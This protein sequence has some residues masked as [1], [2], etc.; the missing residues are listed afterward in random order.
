MNIANCRLM[1]L[2]SRPQLPPL[3]VKSVII[4]ISN[5]YAFHPIDQV[6]SSSIS[7]AHRCVLYAY[8][9]AHVA[10]L[11]CTLRTMAMTACKP[12]AV[13]TLSTL[14][15]RLASDVRFVTDR[16]TSQLV[17]MSHEYLPAPH[18]PTPRSYMPTP[19]STTRDRAQL[20]A[21]T[22]RSEAG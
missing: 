6:P 9:Y 22:M 10:C 8:T 14:S 15:T 13:K 19:V 5:L 12:S 18:C 1:G 20:T 2:A 11:Y 17:Q 4:I 3:D 16:Y 7:R 21:D